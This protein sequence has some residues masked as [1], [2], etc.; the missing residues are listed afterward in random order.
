MGPARIPGSTLYLALRYSPEAW[1]Q[2]GRG[3]TK[4]LLWWGVTVASSLCVWEDASIN[5]W[6][7]T[8]IVSVWILP[9]SSLLVWV[10]PSFCF[11]FG[12]LFLWLEPPWAPP[13]QPGP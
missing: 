9:S 1:L 3:V 2:D 7:N 11:L 4:P 13:P 10:S 5:L 8:L 6:G 12:S